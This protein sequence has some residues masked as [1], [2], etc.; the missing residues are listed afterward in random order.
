[1]RLKNKVA[2]VTGGGLGMGREAALR[3]AAEGASVVVADVDTPAG[4][5]TVRAIREAG[6]AALFVRSDVSQ[7]AE[8]AALMQAAVDRYGGLDILYSNAAIQLHGQDTVAHELS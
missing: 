6:G 4:E 8:I 3:L 1:M 2:V 7:A 5:D